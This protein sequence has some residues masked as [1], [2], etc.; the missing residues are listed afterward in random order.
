MFKTLRWRLFGAL[1][2]VVLLTIGLSSGLTIFTTALQFEQLTQEEGQQRA[3][4]LAPLIEASF[5]LVGD[6]ARIEDPFVT[7]YGLWG[8][9]ALG[10]D[11]FAIAAETMGIDDDTLFDM[12]LTMESLTAVSEAYNVPASQ[13]ADA[14]WT[15]EW[16]SLQM[17]VA[18]GYLSAADAEFIAAD[19]EKEID[20]FLKDDSW[21][22]SQW[23]DTVAGTL[24]LSSDELSTAQRNGRSVQSLAVEQSVTTN[25]LTQAIVAAETADLG[26]ATINDAEQI[27]FVSSTIVKARA[28][29]NQEPWPLVDDAVED[30]IFAE[31]SLA[32]SLLFGD[33]QLLIADENGRIVYDNFGMLLGDSIDPALADSGVPLWNFAQNQPLGTLV[34]ATGTG[35]Y[36]V[37]EL[38][39]LQGITQSALISG[40][41]AGLG[42]LLVGLLIAQRIT[43][44]VTALTK[45]AQNLASGRRVERL[46]IRSQDELGQMSATFNEMADAIETQQQLRS[47]LIDD[48]SHE[49]NTPLTL[50]QLE[51]EGLKDGMQSPQQTAVQVQ[52]EIDL[53]HNLVNDLALV[54]N[55]EGGGV[56]LE[57][58]PFDWEKL[59]KTA[60]SRWQP[61]AE[62]KQITLQLVL[63]EPIPHITADSRRL[64]QVLGNL[65]GNALQHTPA[66]GTVI[67][68]SRLEQGH[69]VTVVQDSGV[70]IPEADLPHIFDRFY[71][72]D[73]SR[74][75]RS[76][77]RGLGLAIVRQ[78]VEQHS[79]RVW[80]TSKP[81]Q[82]SQFGI[83]LPLEQPN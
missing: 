16:E 70:G 54:A 49:L 43:T 68:S 25:S 55:L 34:V 35:F 41:V 6:W 80:A 79:G 81:E 1:G 71:R 11:W 75:R 62:A 23:D 32:D 66:D 29:V 40:V 4:E 78:I 52:R 18:E 63:N 20:F 45:A 69:L 47:R 73:L 30:A 39:F 74:N 38:A 3:A 17:A 58:E 57:A 36:D 14:I 28:Y 64:N 83:E 82:G 22:D 24:G 53:L 5:F 7:D 21:R 44:P 59:V 15:A 42:A 60:V 10:V 33:E 67:V 61:Q 46:P 51:L 13:L 65:I 31:S 48:I 76:G 2:L 8:D 77:G 72:A 50:I 9:E 26:A 12:L 19:L 27:W 37:Q 56:A